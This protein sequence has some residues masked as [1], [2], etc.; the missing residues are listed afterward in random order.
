M[1]PFL[2]RAHHPP[3]TLLTVVSTSFSNPPPFFRRLL[4]V[5]PS[6]VPQGWRRCCRDLTAALS[7]APHP[8]E[9][10]HPRHKP[11]KAC[12]P[13]EADRVRPNGQAILAAAANRDMTGRVGELAMISRRCELGCGR[14]GATSTA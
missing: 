7:P 3:A 12:W 13:G 4:A 14:L 9:T 11:G 6:D 5:D 8:R 10:S 1:R 2:P